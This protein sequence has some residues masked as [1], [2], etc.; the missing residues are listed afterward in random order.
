MCFF[1]FLYQTVCYSLQF[2]KSYTK[3]CQHCNSILYSTFSL[4]R[5]AVVRCLCYQKHIYKQ[6]QQKVLTLYEMP[7]HK[8]LENVNKTTIPLQK[9]YTS[10]FRFLLL[11]IFCWLGQIFLV[12]QFYFIFFFGSSPFFVGLHSWLFIKLFMDFFFFFISLRAQRD[13]KR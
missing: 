1:S 6:Q 5:T 7:H 4:L 13:G 12:C 2:M 3:S 10:V 8:L 9:R 11:L